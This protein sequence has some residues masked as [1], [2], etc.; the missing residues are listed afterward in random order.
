[1][2]AQDVTPQFTA[3]WDWQQPVRDR[4]TG[5][6]GDVSI[7][8]TGPVFLGDVQAAVHRLGQDVPLSEAASVHLQLDLSCTGILV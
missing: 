5:I 1:M 2:I 8:Y 6:W 4:N 7:R 3:G